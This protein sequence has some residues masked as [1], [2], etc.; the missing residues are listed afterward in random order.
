MEVNKSLK[1]AIN[2]DEYIALRTGFNIL[3]DIATEMRDASVNSFILTNSWQSLNRELNITDV[4][5][6]KDSLD[7]FL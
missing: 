6:A 4:L 7:K 1:V 3:D 5:V 2:K